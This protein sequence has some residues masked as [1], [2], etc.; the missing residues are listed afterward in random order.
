MLLFRSRILSSQFLTSTAGPVSLLDSIKNSNSN[1]KYY[2][3]SSSEMY[4]GGT[5]EFLNEIL[6]DPK[7][8]CSW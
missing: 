7:A 2:Q 3:A 6:F 5:E 4:G 8:L 1:I